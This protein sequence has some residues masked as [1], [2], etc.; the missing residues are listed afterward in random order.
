MF[1]PGDVVRIKDSSKLSH[2]DW[3][4][5]KTTFVVSET[6]GGT[7]RGRSWTHFQNGYGNYTDAFELVEPGLEELVRKANDGFAAIGELQTRFDGKVECKGNLAWITEGNA[8]A[9]DVAKNRFAITKPK[10]TFPALRVGGYD[11]TVL[12]GEDRPLKIGCQ[13]MHFAHTLE[14]LRNMTRGT[15]YGETT[16]DIDLRGCREG[17]REL[18]TGKL[19]SWA[20]AVKLLETMEAYQTAVR[21]AA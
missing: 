14:A 17:I 18:N 7:F 2:S 6:D 12:E 3:G 9:L 1:K 4:D 13:R 16:G 19:I 20:D 15:S 8:V 21:E 5:G 11:V 10:P